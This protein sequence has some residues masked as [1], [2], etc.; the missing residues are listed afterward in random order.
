M[1]RTEFVERALEKYPFLS[2]DIIDA[3]VVTYTNQLKETFNHQF[4]N[5]PKI[6]KEGNKNDIDYLYEEYD[7]ADDT[8]IT[9]LSGFDILPYE[10]QD[11]E[12]IFEQIFNGDPDYSIINFFKH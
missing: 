11:W 4:E 1:S 6:H 3:L 2:E 10:E 12:F 8:G 7:I 9:L 5:Y